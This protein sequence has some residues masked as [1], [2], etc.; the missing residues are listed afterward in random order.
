MAQ[1]EDCYTQ[2]MLNPPGSTSPAKKRSKESDNTAL[3]NGN[4]NHVSNGEPK[5]QS[6]FV[7][8]LNG[9][10][11]HIAHVLGQSTSDDS[12]PSSNM[13]SL[14]IT[15]EQIQHNLVLQQRLRMQQAFSQPSPPPMG[16]QPTLL[17][18]NDDN[19][20][21][22]PPEANASRKQPAPP[23]GT[24]LQAQLKS[25]IE[26]MQQQRVHTS[27][28]NQLK[29]QCAKLQSDNEVLKQQQ[30]TTWLLLQG[31]IQRGFGPQPPS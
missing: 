2:T 27:E 21:E 23:L 16:P 13:E 9:P 19:A 17:S 14:G 24:V 28:L 7:A 22:G 31:V 5:V 11:Q 4:S 30:T 1:S 18:S 12:Q 8:S 20:A 6:S 25:L 15:Q 10:E 29:Q 26:V 3:P